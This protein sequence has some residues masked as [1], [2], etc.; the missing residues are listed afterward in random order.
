MVLFQ[1]EEG[2]KEEHEGEA[3]DDPALTVRGT[4]L[5]PKQ[6]RTL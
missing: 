6:V 3:V 4:A 2:A 5:T 1:E